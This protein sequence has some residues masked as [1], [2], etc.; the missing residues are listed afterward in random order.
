MLDE[1]KMWRL[2]MIQYMYMMAVDQFHTPEPLNMVSI[3]LFHDAVE[4]FLALASE[5]VDAGKTGKGF[6]AYWEAINQKLPSK[7]FGQKDGMSRLNAARANWKHH[8]IRLSA[9]EIDDFQAHAATFFG[10]IPRRY[11]GFPLRKYQWQR[12]Y[13][14][15]R[16]GI[17]C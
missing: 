12:L 10:R 6:L 9:T 5:H 1:A 15:R 8:G 2:A 14:L 16:Y 4:L 11:S 13:R 7:D 17:A 3:L